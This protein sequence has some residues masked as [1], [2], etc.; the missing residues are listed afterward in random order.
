MRD[1]A[2]VIADM[3]KSADIVRKNQNIIKKL[4]KVD[5]VIQVEND[6]N[7]ACQVLD[8]YGGT[9][10]LITFKKNDRTSVFSVAS[11]MQPYNSEQ[12]PNSVPFNTFTVRKERDSGAKTELDKWDWSIKHGGQRPELFMQGYYDYK[13]ET[14]KT[15]AVIRL[16]DLRNAIYDEN[17]LC[18][19][20]EKNSPNSR[21]IPIDWY[22]LI[23]NGYHIH[24]YP[25][26]ETICEQYEYWRKRRT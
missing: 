24:V 26:E 8:M 9:D 15:L 12:Y 14:I 11:R 17:K 25:D 23:K 7:R 3:N 20:A 5:E 19:L 4:L 1:N 18:V 6:P 16:L 21:F 2:K 13:D 22:S 10:Y